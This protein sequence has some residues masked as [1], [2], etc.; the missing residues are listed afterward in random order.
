MA[1]V[2]SFTAFS[3][4][5]LLEKHFPV[6]VDYEFTARMEDDLDAIA[7]GSQDMI[8]WLGRF[9]FGSQTKSDKEHHNDLAVGLRAL[10]SDNLGE[11]DAR[12]IN[13]L[14]IGPGPSGEPMIVRVGRYGPYIQ[15]GNATASVAEDLPPDELT[16]EK[17]LSLLA[18]AQSEK[19]L[20][21]DPDS[22]LDVWL[23][24]GRFGA[25]VQ[26]GATDSEAE[27][28]PKRAS[29]LRSMVFD[30]L[31]LKD[32]LALLELPRLIG[33]SEGER[34]EAHNGRYGPYVVKGKERRS[35][36]TEEQIFTMTLEEAL[37]LL[38]QPNRRARR[39]SSEPLRELGEDP[40]SKGVITVRDGRFGP[41]VTDGETNASLRK[42]DTPEGIT[43]ERAAELLVLRRERLAANPKK[44]KKAPAKKAPAKKAPTKK[45]TSKATKKTSTKATKTTKESAPKKT[46]KALGGKASKKPMK[47]TV[48]A[49]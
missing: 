14:P 44:P 4:V 35:L 42:G 40:V 28:K 16:V 15:Y 30:A 25:Y 37:A 8:P 19:K 24:M 1:L 36:E 34:V 27:E 21:V 46:S 12:A 47:P 31:T 49:Q 48:T 23:R 13:S 11:I 2:P 7:H 33:V 38:A 6:L 17:A 26:L 3:V 20:G 45:A 10:V 18:E 9:Y 5:S 29:L 41:Y 32:A 22:G 43:T 39:V